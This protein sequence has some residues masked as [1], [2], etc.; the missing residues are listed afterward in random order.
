MNNSEKVMIKRKSTDPNV[1]VLYDLLEFGAKEYKPMYAVLAEYGALKH[2][3]DHDQL[4]AMFSITMGTLYD[5]A[6]EYEEFRNAITVPKCRIDRYQR[7]FGEA[8]RKNAKR[9]YLI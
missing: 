4:C 9:E 1:I 3:L 5:W 8:A 2:R 7:K 6:I